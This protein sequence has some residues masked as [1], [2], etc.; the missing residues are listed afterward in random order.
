M[1]GLE[2]RQ[3]LRQHH[4][5]HRRS[6]PGIEVDRVEAGAQV[7]HGIV[8]EPAA[9]EI[10]VAIGDRISSSPS[11]WSSPATQPTTK[12]CAVIK[13]GHSSRTAA[14]VLRA[15]AF[16]PA[17]RSWPNTKNGATARTSPPALRSAK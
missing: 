13:R 15:P 8:I 14:T 11:R 6:M 16:M 7:E 4:V 12:V 1:G 17:H 10:L 2:N 3:D 5:H 9:A